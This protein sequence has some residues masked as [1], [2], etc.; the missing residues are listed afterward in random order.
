MSYSSF[1]TFTLELDSTC[2]ENS[3]VLTLQGK[4]KQEKT[5]FVNTSQICRAF[6]LLDQNKVN[7]TLTY[8]LTRLFGYEQ[9]KSLIFMLSRKTKR[10]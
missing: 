4:M 10:T 7:M 8:T 5:I 6:L 9:Y 2:K 3:H 1:S